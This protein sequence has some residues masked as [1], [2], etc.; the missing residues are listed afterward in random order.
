MF[1]LTEASYRL[2]CVSRVLH[3]SAATNRQEARRSGPLLA[4][5]G[6][7]PEDDHASKRSKAFTPGEEPSSA[8]ADSS[9]TLA[10][11]I[12]DAPASSSEV[13]MSVRT[14]MLQLPGKVGAAKQSHDFRQGG[15]ACFDCAWLLQ[16]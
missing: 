9:V 3:A 6:V 12:A 14:T 16:H 11:G 15:D 7:A 13:Q 10:R 2:A 4:V 8:T 5:R 1:I